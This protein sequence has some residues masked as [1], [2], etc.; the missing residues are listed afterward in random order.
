LHVVNFLIFLYSSMLWVWN[1]WKRRNS[2]MWAISLFQQWFLPFPMLSLW[3]LPSV[4]SF[5]YL[6]T[7]RNLF[8]EGLWQSFG[9]NTLPNNNE[10]LQ[11]VENDSQNHCWKGEIAQVE[12]FLLFHQWFLPKQ[13]NV[14]KFCYSFYCHLQTLSIW[15]DPN[16]VVW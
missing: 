8:G 7:V 13:S 14:F 1:C 4:N 12:Q 15:D 16:F 10:I 3:L 6:G 11:V 5:N 9:F 2:S